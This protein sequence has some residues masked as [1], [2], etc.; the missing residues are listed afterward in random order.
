MMRAGHRAGGHDAGNMATPLILAI[1]A[2]AR[3]ALQ[4]NAIA[5]RLRADLVLADSAQR[6]LSAL[7]DRVP[8][9]ILTPTL[10]SGRDDAALTNRLR[11]LGASAAHVQTLTTPILRDA[12]PAA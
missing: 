12:P 4:L 6:A 8:D 9:L 7:R 3:Q 5:E 1:E 2:D 11:E 10:L